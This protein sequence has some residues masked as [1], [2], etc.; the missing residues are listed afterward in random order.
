MQAARRQTPVHTASHAIRAV[1][2]VASGPRRVRPLLIPSHFAY[3]VRIRTMV[4]G[5]TPVRAGARFDHAPADNVLAPAD[6]I[7]A[8]RPGALKASPSGIRWLLAVSSH[9]LAAAR[10]T[11]SIVVGGIG[12]NASPVKPRSAPMS[13]SIHAHDCSGLD[14]SP[15]RRGRMGGR[16]DDPVHSRGRLI[17]L[18]AGYGRIAL[19]Q[20]AEGGVGGERPGRA[21]DRGLGAFGRGAGERAVPRGHAAGRPNQRLQ[22]ACALDV[23]G[24][25]RLRVADVRGGSDAAGLRKGEEGVGGCEA[26]GRGARLRQALRAALGQLGRGHA[27]DAVR[28]EAAQGG[29]ALV[30]RSVRRGQPPR[31]GS[32]AASADAAV[33]RRLGL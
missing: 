1:R 6:L 26:R 19:R 12:D 20:E 2:V 4:S 5:S 18:S 7:Q 25:P 27:V 10:T 11:R 21:V 8:P 9:D 33:R 3:A 30:V 24:P 17:G 28:G 23:G 29:R 16:L 32:A 13:R 31:R 15:L 14:R 22:A